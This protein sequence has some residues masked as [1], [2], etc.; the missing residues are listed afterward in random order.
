MEPW[1]CQRCFPWRVAS[2]WQQRLGYIQ[3][4]ADSSSTWHCQQV[5]WA[6]GSQGPRRAGCPAWAVA[7]R[8]RVSR[9]D[10]SQSRWLVHFPHWDQSRY[11]PPVPVP[12]MVWVWRVRSR[13]ASPRSPAALPLA[14]ALQC[15]ERR[16]WSG[17]RAGEG[18]QISHAGP[19]R[20]NVA[21]CRPS[22]RSLCKRPSGH[23]PVVVPHP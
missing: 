20:T 10:R 5:A 2:P 1:R 23:L 11:S 4:L 12:G 6:S 9:R 16:R 21:Q 19:A 3:H 17:W 14:P 13:S 18:D 7:L 22:S 8:P 15:G